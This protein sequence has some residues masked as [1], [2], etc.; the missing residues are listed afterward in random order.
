MPILNRIADYQSEIVSWRRDLHAH[1]ELMYDLPRTSAFVADKL[2]AF[3]CDEVVTGIGRCGVVGVIRGRKVANGGG[4][5][6]VALR[7]DMDALPV[8]EIT[9]APY[10]STVAGRMHACGHDG[11]TAMLLGA[12]KY[13]ADTRNFSG[14]AVLVFQPAEEGGAGA[15]AMMDDGLLEGIGI[16]EIYGMHNFPGLP[17]GQF[18]TRPGA[19]MAASDYLE[20]AVEGRGG[21]AARPHQTVDA[22]LVGA[23]IVNQVQSIVAR[24]IDPV[25]SAVISICT[26]KAGHTD[27]V[28][29]QTAHLTGTARS[30]S[31]Q[32][33]D[34]VEARLREVVE[35]I[36]RIHGATA[37]LEYERNYPPL[38]NDARATAFAAGV[39]RAVAGDDKVDDAMPPLMIAEDFSFLTQKRPGAYIFTGN[40]DSAGL[41]HP[42]F[43]FCEDAIPFGV[44]YWARL[45]ETA[46]PA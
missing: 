6:A 8:T 4:L 21:H 18:A 43:D 1:P 20:I 24:N 34:L 36:A 23:Q 10:A 2:T 42:A 46:M 16:E 3:G 29:P 19:I 45:I 27:N 28:T 32:V 22:L 40:G 35:G 33:Q 17:V 41:H 37:T 44:S 30:L 5:K 15:R 7:A 38:V 39:A 9:G 25:N 31:P 26:F 11:H 14:Q 12:A 13:L